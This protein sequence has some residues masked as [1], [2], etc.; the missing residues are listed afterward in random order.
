MDDLADTRLHRVA[1]GLP[2]RGP[3]THTYTPWF[4]LN[5]VVA[6][7]AFDREETSSLERF[8]LA[9]RVRA[10]T[11][12]VHESN[13]GVRETVRHFNWPG[14]SFFRVRAANARAKVSLHRPGGSFGRPVSVMLIKTGYQAL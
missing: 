4:R 11:T 1:S 9:A 10:L 12:P 6:S 5:C 7:R 13:N 14:R 3:H 2:P 8:K